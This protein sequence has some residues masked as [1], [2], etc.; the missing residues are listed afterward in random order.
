[1]A[2]PAAILQRSLGGRYAIEREL[3]HGGM[4]VVFLATDIRHNRRVALKVLLPDLAAT[5]GAERFTREIHIA[6]KLAHP[7]ILTLFDSGEADGL[8]YYVMPYVE[9]E[10]LRDRLRR[11]KQLP[12]DEALQITREVADALSYAHSQ[13]IVHR[14]I[15]P[16][17]ILFQFG[18]A[19]VADFGIARALS[20]ASQERLTE[21]G[22]AIGTPAYMSPEQATGVE[23]DSRSDTYSLACVTYEMIVG[24]PPF[25]GATPQV[26]LARHTADIVPRP[27]IARPAVP[28]AV[29]NALLKAL[30]KTPADRYPTASAFA[31]ALA[32][33]SASPGR[34]R[35]W[36]VAALRP[37]RAAAVAS[38]LVLLLI[39]A[40]VWWRRHQPAGLNDMQGPDPRRV[41]VLYFR[42]AGVDSLRPIGEGLT[43][44]LIREL[45]RVRALQVTS[46]NGV[47]PYREADVAPDSVRRALDVGS[48]VEGTLAQAGSRLRVSVSL[49]DASGGSVLG[50]AT[51]ERPASDVFALEDS[52]TTTVAL[53]LRQR[54]GEEVQLREDRQSAHN[55]E[56]WRS[57]QAARAA[58]RSSDS[59]VRGGDTALARRELTRAETLLERAR[60]LDPRWAAPLTERGW[61]GWHSRFLVGSLEPVST[62][63]WTQL[64][65]QYADSALAL[66]PGDPDALALRGTSHYFRYVLGM[67]ANA[68][69]VRAGGDSAEIDLQAATQADPY[70][71]YAWTL[72]SHRFARSGEIAESKLAAM[73]AYEADPYDRD[74]TNTLWQLFTTSEDMGDRLEAIRWCNEGRARFADP[75][76]VECQIVVQAMPGQTPDIPTLWR[77][78][79][80]YVRR[81]PANQRP[82]RQRYGQMEVAMALA[83]AGL[84]DS[85]RAVAVRARADATVDP[86]RNLVQFEMML[87]NILGDRD[88]ALRL[89]AQYFA[90]NPQERT[91]CPDSG[92]RAD[93]WWTRGLREDPRYW[94]LACTNR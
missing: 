56:A 57:L 18:H 82:F 92:L 69:A 27:S 10:S 63:R 52:I 62:G 23:V 5:V 8:L 55:L 43:E 93:T 44:G 59:L 25:T 15:K 3:G 81:W 74:A 45:S 34:P 78:L 14:D 40:G 11:E 77:L 85:A 35:R 47:R 24:S 9:G 94:A 83:R 51:F 37:R 20:A 61:L 54:L 26:V 31:D 21:T 89:A 13:G 68:E 60:L 30:T 2:D 88:E 12:L 80:E 32:G 1:M 4:A 75:W 39:L 41:A 53:F 58:M 29:E 28:A 90:S 64:G 7:H 73:R 36:S 67:G 46:P 86:S 70:Q 17:N 48:I 72:L 50:S 71:A 33:A 84:S 76:W 42:T 16:E 49:V 65:I 22:M 38:A 91:V 79:D 66:S 19:V 87:R 6:A